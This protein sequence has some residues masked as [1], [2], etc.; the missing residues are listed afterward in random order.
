M[1]ERTMTLDG[2]EM[3]ADSTRGWRYGSGVYPAPDGIR[4]KITLV[5]GKMWE[6]E[7]NGRIFYK[8]TE[9]GFFVVDPAN[10]GHAVQGIE[11]GLIRRVEIEAI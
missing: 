6:R 9:S 3:K 10:G 7:Q 2:L 4:V 5:G 11:R 1:P 8:M